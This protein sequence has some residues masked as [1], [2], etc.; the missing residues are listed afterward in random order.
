MTGVRPHITVCICTYKRPALLQRLLDDLARQ[1][2]EDHFSFSIAVVDNDREQSACVIVEDFVRLHSVHTVYCVEPVQNIALARNRAV[3]AA[4]GKYVAFID[5]DEFPVAN[6]LLTLLKC[7]NAYSVDGVLGPVRPHF[8]SDV[9]SWVFRGGFYH[10]PE[11]STGFKMS[12]QECRT[13]NVLF[14]KSVLKGNGLPFRE[15]FGTGSE[16]VD[17]FRRMER[18]G[19]RFIWC[20]EAIV[21]EIVPPH[22]CKRS[23]LIK[24]ALLRGG[25]SL[26]HPEGRWRNVAKAVL[27]IPAYMVAL[28]VLLMVGHHLFMK[29]LV[30]LCDHLGRLLALVR[31][32]P[33]RH[34]EM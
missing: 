29:Y 27:A 1:E 18:K 32:N 22:R 8:G 2:T 4:G 33:F 7:C 12:W 11:H 23:F 28:P 10:R 34:R 20:N 9:P 5:D 15:E 14:N 19:F 6:W 30:K 16:D 31:L 3:A 21:Y 26:R 13:G 17:F 25:N 24:R